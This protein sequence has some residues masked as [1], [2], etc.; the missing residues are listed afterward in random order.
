VNPRPHDLDPLLADL[1]LLDPALD[2]GGGV[3]MDMIRSRAKQLA[4]EESGS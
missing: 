1:P 3:E 4:L 2:E